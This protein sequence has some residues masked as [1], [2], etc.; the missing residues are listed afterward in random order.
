MSGLY[1]FGIVI[2]EKTHAHII[3]IIMTKVSLG[4]FIQNHANLLNI[5]I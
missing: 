1:C 2:Q 4:F 5:T 3:S